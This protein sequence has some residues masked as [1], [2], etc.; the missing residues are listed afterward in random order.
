MFNLKSPAILSTAALAITVVFSSPV[1][2]HAHLKS[3][4]PAANTQVNVSPKVLKL[5]FS[6][7][8]EPVFTGIELTGSHH[9]RIST[10]KTELTPGMH[11]QLSVV[12]AKPLSSGRYQVKWHALSVDGHKTKGAY[13]FRVK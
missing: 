4:E 5:N 12:L 9:Q 8:I 3:Q 13:T 11:N 10:A 1:L 2:A 7:D 6:E